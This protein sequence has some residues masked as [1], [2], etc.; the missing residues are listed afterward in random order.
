MESEDTLKGQ[1]EEYQFSIGW[2]IDDFG[3][4]CPSGSEGVKER[5]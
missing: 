1:R 2:D 5:S 4:E 3:L